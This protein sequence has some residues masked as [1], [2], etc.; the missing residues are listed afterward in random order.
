VAIAD[1]DGTGVDPNPFHSRR[2]RT[3]DKVISRQVESL[4]GRRKEREIIG[5]PSGWAR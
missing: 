3:D 4:R 5:I 2:V 1:V